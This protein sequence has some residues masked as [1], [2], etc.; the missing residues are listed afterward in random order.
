MLSLMSVDQ[1]E[2]T[3][4]YISQIMRILREMASDSPEG[5]DYIEFKRRLKTSK[6]L[7][8]QLGPLQQRLDL[9]ESFIDLDSSGQGYGFESG[10]VTIIDLS[11]PFVDANMACLLFNISITL[12]LGSAGTAG[13]IIA[14]D[15][16][17]KVSQKQN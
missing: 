16:A 3:P 11:C 8:M 7:G 1:S 15:E 14:M 9:L 5:F 13:K 10:G 4:L 6:F 17:H 12:Y 2:S